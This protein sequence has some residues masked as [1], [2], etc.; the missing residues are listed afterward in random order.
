MLVF[1]FI[2]FCG[3]ELLG[4][5]HSPDIS[6]TSLGWGV[7]VNS[8]G[9]TLRFQAPAGPLDYSVLK[10]TRCVPNQMNHQH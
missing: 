1:N 8:S 9:L 2:Q 5:T 4:M 6:L 10:E 3:Y 7:A